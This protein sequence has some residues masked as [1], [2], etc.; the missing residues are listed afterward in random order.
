MKNKIVIIILVFLAFGQYSYSQL[1]GIGQESPLSGNKV[2]FG[3]S[4]PT[5]DNTLVLNGNIVLPIT[6]LGW[7][8]N[9][10]SHSAA[11]YNYMVGYNSSYFRN[12]LVVDLSGVSVTVTSAVLNLKMFTSVPTTGNAEWDIYAVDHTY[13]QLNTD[14]SSALGNLHDGLDIYNDLG[15]GTLY[16]SVVVDCSLPGSTV[17]HISLNAA[18]IANINLARGDYFTMGGKSEPSA[19]PPY[20]GT[21]TYKRINTDTL[22]TK[23]LIECDTCSFIVAVEQT[24]GKLQQKYLNTSNRDSAQDSINN[25]FMFNEIGKIVN[26]NSGTPTILDEYISAP[27]VVAHKILSAAVSPVTVVAGGMAGAGAEV[28]VVGN[29]VAGVISFKINSTLDDPLNDIPGYVEVILDEGYTDNNY[30]VFV[31]PFDTETSHVVS[32]MVAYNDETRFFLTSKTKLPKGSYTFKYM[33]IGGDSSTSLKLNS[34][35]Q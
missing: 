5:T 32:D 3:Y 13:A 12:F 30:I 34:H 16:K 25:P 29:S 14:Y 35:H 19:Y 33:I 24:T 7:F 18:A 28:D 8:S 20:S 27:S 1:S 6:K 31:Q 22:Y 10:G 15:S 9:A 23:G 26:R 21:V 11:N 2:L 4:Y 17:L